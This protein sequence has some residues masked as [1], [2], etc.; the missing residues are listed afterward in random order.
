MFKYLLVDY[1]EEY[2]V[3]LRNHFRQT[4]RVLLPDSTTEAAAQTSRGLQELYGKRVLPD[5]CMEVLHGSLSQLH[6]VSVDPKGQQEVADLA[7][8]VAQYWLLWVEERRL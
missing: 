2:A 6:N 1:A 5:A 8:R 3:N 7:F 4:V